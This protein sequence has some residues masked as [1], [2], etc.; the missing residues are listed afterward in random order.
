MGMQITTYIPNGSR[1]PVPFDLQAG[2]SQRLAH[3]PFRFSATLHHL[4]NWKMTDYSTWVYDHREENELVSGRSDDFIKQFM[5]HVILGVEFIPTRNFIIGLGYNFQ[6]RWE[7]GLPDNPATSGL[8]AGFTVKV[9]KFRVS[10]AIASYHVSGPS[11]VF[12][13]STNLSE[14][15]H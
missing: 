4:T 1:E 14:F 9:S 12:S 2:F 5:R 15:M 8:S 7:L 3:A 13:V 10:Y 11:N 6:R